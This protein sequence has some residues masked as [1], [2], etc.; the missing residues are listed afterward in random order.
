[1]RG[2]H[3]RRLQRR[4]PQGIIPAHAG[5]T[6]WWNWCPASRWDHPRV[7]GEHTTHD[8]FVVA[9][10]GSSPRMRGTR[11]R[12]RGGN[13]LRGTI[14][15]YAGNT[16]CTA[17]WS[18]GTRDHPRVCGEHMMSLR[19]IPCDPGSSPRMRGTHNVRI[20]CAGIIGI[21]PAY[22]GNTY[23]MCRSYTVPRDHPRVCGEHLSDVPVVYRPTGS[24]PRMRGT[25]ST[26]TMVVRTIGIIP[27]YA[28]NTVN[29]M[30]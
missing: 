25:R 26:V 30:N 17:R 14:P 2:T 19:F 22:A 5:N 10:L 29:G 13:A 4:H 9:E 28:G 12:R 27:A 15:A 7:C 6:W 1:M 24:S 8:L 11:N 16:K 3:S 23:R 21:I 18:A 20:A